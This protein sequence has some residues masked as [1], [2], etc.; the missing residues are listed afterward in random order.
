MTFALWSHV[1]AM[2][3]APMTAVPCS[4]LF[5]LDL[6]PTPRHS[7]RWV[8]LLW[9]RL[10]LQIRLVFNHGENVLYLSLGSFRALV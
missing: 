7:W 3:R 8:V 9:C 5:A 4:I 6:R 10:V 2:E 1:R